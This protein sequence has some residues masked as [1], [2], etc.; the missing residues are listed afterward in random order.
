[1]ETKYNESTPNRP[2]G[3]R[4]LD[5]GFVVSDLDH[6]Y[7][8]LIS[9]DAWQKNDR[10]AITICKTDHFTQVLSLLKKDAQMKESISD[11]L[12]NIQVIKGE[13]NLHIDG[14]NLTMGEA[15]VVTIHPNTVHTIA[16]NTDS[17]LLISTTK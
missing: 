2:D 3:E 1:M 10:N 8:Q 9:E 17:L 15:N 14:N 5:A 11:N 16:I 7:N 13:I 12:I 6:Y 4:I